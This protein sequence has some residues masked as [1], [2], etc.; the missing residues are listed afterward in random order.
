M[1]FG[2]HAQ[3]MNNRF[4]YNR[5]IR[6]SQK[7]KF[8]EKNRDLIYKKNTLTIDK[9]GNKNSFSKDIVSKIRAKIK[10]R[11]QKRTRK[12]ILTYLFY[13]VVVILILMLLF[14]F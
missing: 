2:G 12:I 11:A 13:A 7:P 5:S 8:K 6:P 3:D 9:E 10:K 4:K 14:Q 1:S